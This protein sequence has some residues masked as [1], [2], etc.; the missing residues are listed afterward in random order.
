MHTY[1]CVFDRVLK[2][3][4]SKVTSIGLKWE[5]KDSRQKALL[6]EPDYDSD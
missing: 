6:V 1:V 3:Q 4:F 5:T 2:E